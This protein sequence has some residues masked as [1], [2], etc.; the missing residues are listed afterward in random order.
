MARP[1]NFDLAAID[2]IARTQ[3]GIITHRQLRSLNMSGSSIARWAGTG[4]RIARLLP[5]TYLVHRG[6]PT[7]EERLHAGLAYAGGGAVLSGGLDLHLRGIRHL[8]LAPELLPVHVL[9]PMERQTKSASFTIVERTLR[10]PTPEMVDGIPCAPVARALFDCARRHTAPYQVR[11]VM[12]EA[13]Q[14]GMVTLPELQLELKQGQRRWTGSLRE[15]LGEAV[16][17][18][19]SIKEAELRALIL[20]SDL[21]EPLWNPTLV[22][23]EGEFIAEPDGYYPDLGIAL[24]VDSREHHFSS[25]DGFEKTWSRHSVYN[26]HQIVAE[27]ILPVTISQN[28]AGVIAAIRATRSAHCG[29]QTPP[30]Q[31]FPRLPDGRRDPRVTKF[32]PPKAR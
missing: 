19:R 1:R 20:H 5:G 21:P 32:Y 22:S 31:V 8:P 7:T 12:L 15:V 25:I 2:D 4:G 14:R 3:G 16:T 26:R 27:R 6:T 11:A 17:G 30:V 24:E 10:P 29:R 13:V 18:V 28:P 9:V 23:N